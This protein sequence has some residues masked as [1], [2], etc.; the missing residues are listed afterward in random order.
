MLG[1]VKDL[2]SLL[3]Y[4][5]AEE[6]AKFKHAGV[7]EGQV[8]AFHNKKSAHARNKTRKCSHCGKPQH[9][10][11]NKDRETVCKAMGKECSVCH[12]ANH[13]A[14]QCKSGKP[15]TAAAVKPAKDKP[16]DRDIDTEVVP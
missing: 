13:F 4:V 12:R 10:E 9:G 2:P 1:N 3:N 16:A 7:N 15:T 5:A 8:D 6:S 14:G 11:N